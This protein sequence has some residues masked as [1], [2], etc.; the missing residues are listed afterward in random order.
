MNIRQRRLISDYEKIREEF[1]RHRHIRV[2]PQGQS[3]YEK[4]QITYFVKSLCWDDQ[5][6]CP[7][8]RGQHEVEIYLTQ[9]YPRGKPQCTISTPIFH[10][11]FGARTICIGDYWAASSSLADTIIKIGEMLQFRDYNPKSPLNAAAARWAIENRSFLPVGKVDLYTPEPDVEIGNNNKAPSPADDD[12][13][14]I[15]LNSQEA[16]SKELS[17]DLDLDIQLK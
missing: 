15:V 5:R 1:A 9:D 13:F 10:P 11:N 8:E 17:D 16:K 2:Q 3:P 4:Y 14:E 7:I 12:D 6:N